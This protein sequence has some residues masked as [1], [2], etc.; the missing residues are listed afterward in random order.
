MIELVR[1][2]ATEAD[3]IRLVRQ[4][5]AYLTTVDGDE[6][7]FYD[8]YNHSEEI[9]FVVLAYQDGMAVGCGAIKPYSQSTMEVKRMFVLPEKRGEG[10]AGRIL[11]ELESWAAELGAERCILETG[12]RQTEAIRLYEKCRYRRIP[13]YEPYQGVE[14]S[15]CYQKETAEKSSGLF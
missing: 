6:H 1:T 15:V 2:N 5:D 8:Q 14:N 12:K 13:N 3:F 11:N 9:R 4:L 7:A 10:I